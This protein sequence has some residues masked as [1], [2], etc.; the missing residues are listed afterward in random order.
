MSG[1]GYGPPAAAKPS[2][3]V[4]AHAGAILL[5]AL[6][7]A[8]CGGRP[9]VA[10]DTQAACEASEVLGQLWDGLAEASGIARDPR[11]PDLFW[12]HNDSGNEA[13]LYAVDAEGRLR[14]RVPVFGTANRDVEDIAVARCEGGWCLWLAD[15]G[16]NAGVRLFVEVH[17][18]PLPPLPTVPVGA[19]ASGSEPLHPLATYTL[20]YP[21]GARD[22]ESLVVDAGRRE[23]LIVTK[24]RDG[25]VSVYAAGLDTLEAAHQPVPLQRLGRLPV[26]TGGSSAQLVTAADLSPDGARLAV[27]SYAAL[28]LFPWAGTEAFDSLT[29]PASSSLLGLLEPQ[30]EGLAF[31]DD[32]EQVYLAS[33]ARDER[34]PQLSRILCPAR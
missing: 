18:L 8:A 5:L 2:G 34:P 1:P 16:D 7:A 19:Q 4:R 33:E 31:G 23:L 13:A 15:I 24:G 21:D 11:R 17:R 9:S 10:R 29:T 32:G 26:P 25:V 3:A 6:L 30:G 22:A 14:A 28:Y 12:L 27:R 20:V